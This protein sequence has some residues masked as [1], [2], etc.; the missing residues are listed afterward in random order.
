VA[1]RKSGNRRRREDVDN[2]VK[3]GVN[4]ESKRCAGS[5]RG[6]RD[7]K[8]RQVRLL[9]GGGCLVSDSPLDTDVDPRKNGRSEDACHHTRGRLDTSGGSFLEQR[10]EKRKGKQR[11]S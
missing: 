7:G 10:R 1:Q 4:I 6:W 8:I 2:Q 5:V 9:R 3:P 11:N